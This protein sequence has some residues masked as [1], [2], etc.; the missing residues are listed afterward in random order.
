MSWAAIGV[1]VAGAVV[2]GA[3]SYGVTAAT[4]PKTPDLASSSREM[5]DLNANMLPIRR[6]IEAAAAQ[7][8][9]V[10]VPGQPQVTMA[11]QAFVPTRVNGVA[12]PGQGQWVPY[13]PAEW[14]P[15][16]KYAGQSLGKSGAPQM[17]QVPTV[18]STARTVDFKGLGTADV[19]GKVAREMAKLQLDLA[20]KYDPQFIEES[21]KQAKLA[22]P[23]GFAA[24]EKMNELIQQ[25]INAKPERPVADLL[26]KQISDELSAARD[27]RLTPEMRGV[28]DSAVADALRSRGGNTPEGNFEEP[29]TTGFAGEQRKREAAQKAIGWLSSGATPE[30][31][32]Y[33]RE[34]QNLSNLSAL[35]NGRTPQSQFAALSG[36]QQGPTPFQPG[37]ALPTMPNNE[38]G[39]Q[40]AALSSWGTQ[41][42]AA[43]NQVSPWLAGITSALNIGGQVASTRK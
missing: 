12:Q 8:G 38:A 26:D 41:M 10:T 30:D 20:K 42:S 3:I 29:L 28:L 35:V 17:R 13:N 21:L 6:A 33:R 19:E 31:V 4:Q 39:A 40:G 24:R 1:A 43:N 36:A 37:N 11:T 14:Q 2:S 9:K 25:Q 7:G 22:D 5:S 18:T 27:S 23:E 32:E 16:G 15:G 34:Q